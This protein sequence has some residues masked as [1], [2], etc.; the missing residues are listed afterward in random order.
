MGSLYYTGGQ[1]R[2]TISD[3]ENKLIIRIS[4][5]GKGISEDVLEKI[6]REDLTNV[7]KHGLGIL[8]SKQIAQLHGGTLAIKNQD[9]GLQVSFLFNHV[10]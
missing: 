8:I 6:T 10:H 9:P 1:I 4:D 7:T 5:Q 3:P 2:V